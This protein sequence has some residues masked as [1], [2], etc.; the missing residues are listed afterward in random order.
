MREGSA[1]FLRGL[2][3]LEVE[4]CRPVTVDESVAVALGSRTRLRSLRFAAEQASGLL[5]LPGGSRD[6]LQPCGLSFFSSREPEEEGGQASP[7]WDPASFRSLELRHITWNAGGFARV[8]AESS[9]SALAGLMSLSLENSSCH[10]EHVAAVARAPAARGLTSLG[11]NSPCVTLEGVRALARSAGLPCLKDL[12]LHR[13]DLVAEGAELPGEPA[14]LRGLTSL[15]LT[16]CRFNSEGAR[17]FER[18]LDLRTLRTLGL[19]VGPCNHEDGRQ[20]WVACAG[21]W[22]AAATGLTTLTLDSNDLE[23]SEVE[24]VLREPAGLRKLSALRLAGNQRLRGA[25]VAHLARLPRLTDLDLERT[26]VG[27]MGA[28]ILA[29]SAGFSTLRTLRLDESSI[30]VRGLKVY[31]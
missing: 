24:E 13:S 1:G 19:H 3:H 23:S 29:S 4:E 8:V 14:G 27:D 20:A 6:G 22:A 26:R 18:L 21:R 2:R 31:T 30:T 28:A 17:A 5:P 12:R 9:P 11:L 10:D 15:S 25:V 16:G 7:L